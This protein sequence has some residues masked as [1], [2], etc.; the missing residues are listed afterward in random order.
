MSSPNPIPVAAA[1]RLISAL[2]AVQQF[3]VHIGAV[4]K[5]LFILLALLVPAISFALPSSTAKSLL[6]LNAASVSGP[7]LTWNF[8]G[9][10]VVECVGVWN[11]ATATL[12]FLGPDGVT[13]VTAGTAATFTANG[14][15]VFYL[16]N[17][18][19]Q[20]TITAAGGSTSLTCAAYPLY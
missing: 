10:G 8:G 20:M 2:Q 18:L 19:V 3:E 5:K 17:G 15:G 9:A 14:A 4:M 11:G 16:P 13:L 12:Q 7:Q 1:P 6:L